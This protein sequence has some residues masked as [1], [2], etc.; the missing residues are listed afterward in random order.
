MQF[1]LRFPIIKRQQDRYSRIPICWR[2]LKKYIKLR[3]S[4]QNHSIKIRYSCTLLP[5]GQT[6]CIESMRTVSLLQSLNHSRNCGS[7]T[8]SLQSFNEKIRGSGITRKKEAH[9]WCRSPSFESQ[10]QVINLI[11]NKKSSPWT[12]NLLLDAVKTKIRISKSIGNCFNENEISLHLT[13]L[14]GKI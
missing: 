6:I 3:A 12:R 7:T 4:K 14:K 5:G 10:S 8:S 9:E 11:T 1:P 2:L 13:Y